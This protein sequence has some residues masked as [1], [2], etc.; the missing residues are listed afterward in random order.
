M[1]TIERLVTNYFCTFKDLFAILSYTPQIRRLM[2]MRSCDGSDFESRLPLKLLNLT[3]I[4]IHGC[5]ITFDEFK[6]FIRSLGCK[7]TALDVLTYYVDMNYLY[8]NQW[9]EFIVECLPQLEKFKFEYNRSLR[10]KNDYP[11]HPEDLNEFTSP[12]WIQRK[13][14]VEVAMYTCD[15]KY[16]IG[17]YK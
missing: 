15:I 10:S 8:G 14:V 6:M 2:V 12:F 3:S 1:S 5:S 17:P 4:S 11:I 7:L 13:L 16:T 9:K